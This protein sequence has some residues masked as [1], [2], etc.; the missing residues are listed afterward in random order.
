MVSKKAAWLTINT[1][2]LSLAFFIRRSVNL[3]S[4]AFAGIY[5]LIVLSDLFLCWAYHAWVYPTY[6]D[7]LR[8]IPAPKG[9]NKWIGYAFQDLGKDKIQGTSQ[10]T[11]IEELKGE[12]SVRFFDLFQRPRIMPISPRAL[13]DVLTTKCYDF[14]KPA[15][16]RSGSILAILG[17][18]LLFAEGGVHKK[19]RK[20]LNPAFSFRNVKNMFPMFWNGS[21][22]LVRL[23][24]K[25]VHKGSGSAVI[26]PND[27]TS[28]A[29]L[30]ILGE[31]GLGQSFGAIENPD[32]PTTQ[33][34]NGLFSV[35]YTSDIV[36]A[37]AEA[38]IPAS[39]VMLVP[40]P[41][42]RNLKKN[43]RVVREVCAKII[44]ERRAKIEKQGAEAGNDLLSLIL[45]Q[46]E[47]TYTDKEMVEQLATFLVAGHETTAAGV[48]WAV[49][50]FCKYPAIQQRLRDAIRESIP[51]SAF[52]PGGCATSEQV[53]SCAYLQ[54]FCAE[55]LRLFAPVPVTVREAVVDTS[56]AGKPIPK[57]TVVLLAPWSVNI[58][59]AT[60]G[61]DAAEFK[62]ERWLEN[63]GNG[64]AKSTYASMTF[65]HGPRSCIGM[66]FAKSEFACLVAGWAA[67]FETS[68]HKEGDWKEPKVDMLGSIA[69]RPASGWKVDVKVVDW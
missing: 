42:N 53:E 47:V 33:A 29:T 35:K 54:A 26:E 9:W 61:P 7:P 63:P 40:H 5:T 52:Q 57:G 4:Y 69:A 19:Q 65:I 24:E 37:I 27:V 44:H 28:R 17:N 46:K 14:E 38:I 13:T 67:R 1:A 22:E 11:W 68:F 30:D 62:P 2:C 59:T 66:G 12:D 21:M 50:V 16:M 6:F 25:E 3:P 32:N 43:T 60:W 36:F 15:S 20:Q 56:I 51:A 31:A 8:A 48:A 10:R 64:G 23:I 58:A 41:R 45:S 55:I 18:G 39:I 49:F 34:Y